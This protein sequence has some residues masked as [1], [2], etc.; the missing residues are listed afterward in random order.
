MENGEN[1][2]NQHF[3]LFPHCFLPYQRQNFPNL[4]NFNS[5]SANALNL[6]KSKMLLFGFKRVKKAIKG[7][8]VFFFLAENICSA[9]SRNLYNSRIVLDKVG[10]L[11]LSGEVGLPTWHGSIPK[12]SLRKV[13]IGTK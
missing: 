5:S 12:S 11:T 1:A 6:V 13:G 3:L 10:I 8:R 4:A 2:V 9:Q 7:H